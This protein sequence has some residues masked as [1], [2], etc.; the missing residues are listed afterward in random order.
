M[1]K[2]YEVEIER[3]VTQKS[4]N[5]KMFSLSGESIPFGGETE[6]EF[7]KRITLEIARISLKYPQKEG[8]KRFIIY[9]FDVYQG[10]A[11][12][13]NF[14]DTKRNIILES[15]FEFINK[16]EDAGVPANSLTENGSTTDDI[17]EANPTKAK[18]TKTT[19]A[20]KKFKED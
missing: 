19:K 5:N 8:L 9:L 6:D 2:K 10:T 3:I 17:V 15:H 14:Y 18:T 7:A 4:A 11:Y 1:N 16:E 12:R 20:K 13:I